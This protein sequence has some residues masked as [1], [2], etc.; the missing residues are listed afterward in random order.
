MPLATPAAAMSVT[1]ANMRT[2][3]IGLTAALLVAAAGAQ[4]AVRS[5]ETDAVAQKNS[6]SGALA[7]AVPAKG[8]VEAYRLHHG[9]FPGNN[10]EAGLNSPDSYRTNDIKAIAIAEDGRIDVTLTA[11][12]GV[13]GGVIRLTPKLAAG[14]ASAV[15]WKCASAN[16]SKI[17]DATDG[18]CEYA[19]QP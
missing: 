18:V 3:L 8:A 2:M 9:A 5:S 14:E 6:I 7:A 19:N 1:E 17:G 12:S 10:V 16:Y 15:E 11:V 4:E 13:D